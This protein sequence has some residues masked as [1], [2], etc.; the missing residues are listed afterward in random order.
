MTTF[1]VF[2]AG[3][4]YIDIEAARP[5]LARKEASALYPGCRVTKIKVVK[6]KANA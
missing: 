1:R 5:E 3:N 4:G 6:E 2:M